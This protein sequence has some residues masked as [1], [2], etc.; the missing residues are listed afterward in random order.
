MTQRATEILTAA[1]QLSEA[2][3]ME[4]I[5]GLEESLDGPGLDT[6]D[7]TDEEFEAELNRRHEELMRDPSAGVPWE[8]VLRK[9][10]AEFPDVG[11]IPPSGRG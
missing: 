4:L 3:R 7:M 1:L 8:E 2:E 6:D 11:P 10:L 9:T 5:E